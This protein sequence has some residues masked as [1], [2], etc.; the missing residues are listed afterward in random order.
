VQRKE[1]AKRGQ[2]NIA[3][4][5]REHGKKRARN[6]VKSWRE[7]IGGWGKPGESQPD[8]RE[9]GAKAKTKVCLKT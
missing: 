5:K 8:Y 1:T 2:S 7:Q 6:H 4:M 3:M 9:A